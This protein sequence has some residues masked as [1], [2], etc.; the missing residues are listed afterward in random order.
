MKKAKGLDAVWFCPANVNPFKRDRQTAS[1]DHRINMVR[2]AIEGR[3]GFSLLDLEAKRDGPSYTVETLRELMKIF[4]ADKDPSTLY[5][6]MS[7]ESVPGFYKW[8]EAEEIVKMVP[9][10]IGSR[11]GALNVPDSKNPAIDTAIAKGRVPTKLFNISSTEIRKRIAA[12]EDCTSFLPEK[13]IDYIT[14]NH[15]Y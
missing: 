13:V 14:E 7:E 4:K 8:K 10:L 9:L 1:I 6:I 15:L 12:G 11:L 3:S 5:L 2:L